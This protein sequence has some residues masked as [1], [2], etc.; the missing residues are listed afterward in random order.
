MKTK[1]TVLTWALQITAGLILGW[2]GFLKLTGNPTDIF[3]FGELDMEPFGRHLIGV[4][5]IVAGLL[6]L[7]RAYSASA[8][9]LGVGI[10]FG[11]IIAHATI[12]GFSVRGDNGRHILLLVIVLLSC[13]TVLVLRRR[14]LPLIGETL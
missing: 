7:T 5:E 14:Q 11:A 6:L 12:L 10:M 9:L 13:A 3:L 8:A 4:L 2:V 1:I